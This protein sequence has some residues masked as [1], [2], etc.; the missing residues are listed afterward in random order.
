MLRSCR[1]LCW[2][3]LIIL[4][5][6]IPVLAQAKAISLPRAT[7]GENPSQ[8]SIPVS[9]LNPSIATLNRMQIYAAQGMADAIEARAA[10]HNKNLVGLDADLSKVQIMLELIR[11]RMPGAEFLAMVR[12]IRAKMHFEDNQQ[13]QPFFSHLFY[14]LDD[15]G[16]SKLVKRARKY[17]TQAQHALKIPN[18][19]EAIKALKK[20]AATFENPYI[21]PPLRASSSN[22]QQA[23]N[24]LNNTSNGAISDNL[25]KSLAKHLETLHRAFATYPVIMHPDSSFPL[26]N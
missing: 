22:L 4:I 14:A 7:T 25:L 8:V 20:S 18:R 5:L 11:S 17:L 13:V 10:L 23:F 24:A 19:A 1:R 26:Q 9:G 15:L 16:N 2:P 21:S 3:L 12:A 6:G